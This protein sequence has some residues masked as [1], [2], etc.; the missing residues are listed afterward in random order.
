MTE[1]ESLRAW[2]QTGSVYDVM[3]QKESNLEVNY[4]QSS[5]LEWKSIIAI[6]SRQIQCLEQNK[7]M[8][9]AAGKEKWLRNEVS[10]RSAQ[11]HAL[12][13]NEF[14]T[15]ALCSMMQRHSVYCYHCCPETHNENPLTQ[16]TTNYNKTLKWKNVIS[17]VPLIKEA[18][19]KERSWVAQL[20]AIFLKTLVSVL[21]GEDIGFNVSRSH[22]LLKRQETK[23]KQT[24]GRTWLATNSRTFSISAINRRQMKLTPAKLIIY[25]DHV[26]NLGYQ[27]LHHIESLH[28]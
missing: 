15:T 24:L 25:S 2:E 5:R 4:G 26:S 3:S 19:W 9:T 28:K 13:N 12:A 16:N 18:S 8:I 1:P 10:E 21:F 20:K 22:S 23:Y 11:T 27:G 14:I 6:D 17:T 7:G